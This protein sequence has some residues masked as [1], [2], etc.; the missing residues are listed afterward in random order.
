MRLP[1]AS[2]PLSRLTPREVEVLRQVA[3]GEPSKAIA[4]TLGIGVRTVETHR[5]N[6]MRK[7]E[8]WSVAELTRFAIERG[9]LRA[10]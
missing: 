7:L 2:D 3:E 9:L 4:A 10:P 8:L 1:E 5:A 6:L